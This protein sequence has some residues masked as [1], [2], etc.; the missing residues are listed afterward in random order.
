MN[1]IKPKIGILLGDPSGIGPELISKLLVEDELEKANVLVIGEKA[2]LEKANKMTGR[3][4][5]LRFIDTIDDIKFD[6]KTK[7]FLDIT[8]GRNFIYE[9]SKCSSESGQSVLNALNLALD[10]VK[11]KKIDA[12][13]FGPFNKTSMKLGGSKFEDELHLM[14]KKL[15]VE[16]FFCEFNVIDNFWTARVTSHIPL[17][18][19]SKYIKKDNIIK[20]IKLINNAMKLNGIKNPRVAVQALN[21]HAEFGTE[22]KEEIIPAINDAKKQGINADGPLPC[23]TSFITAY[24]NKNH[25]CIVGMYHDAL[26]SG[27][28]AFGFDRGV[29]VQGGLPVPVTTPAH[30]TA[31]DIAG[32]NKANLEPTLQSFKIALTMA[33]NKPNDK[34]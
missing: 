2:I 29:T 21:P 8:D 20:P 15:E 25:D 19:V 32:K 5:N 31:F 34:N 17:S 26:Q 24:K 6:E 1:N 7:F 22:E 27:L 9:T 16:N 23:D 30:G 13:N 33:K 18:E 28:K 11:S 10:L 4:P 3:N 12:I 14:A